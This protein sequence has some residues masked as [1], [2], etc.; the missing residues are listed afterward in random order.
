MAWMMPLLVSVALPML[1]WPSMAP[2]FV[3]PAPARF[4]AGPVREI[5]PV[6]VKA[7]EMLSEPAAICT[8]PP[9]SL[10]KGERMLPG[11]VMTPPAAL[12]SVAVPATMPL[13]RFNVPWLTSV[14]PVRRSWRPEA[15]LMLPRF[16]F[17]PVAERIMLPAPCVTNP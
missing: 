1:P 17:A 8:V 16:W 12:S 10:E 5:R 11:P 13:L 9:A 4:A 14:A 15:R 6:L 2:L 7:C 3:T